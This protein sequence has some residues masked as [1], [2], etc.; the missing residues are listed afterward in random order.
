MCHFISCSALSWAT[1]QSP[2]QTLTFQQL[3]DTP[4][5]TALQRSGWGPSACCPEALPCSAAFDDGS[6]WPLQMVLPRQRTTQCYSNLNKNIFFLLSK[7]ARTMERSD[8]E[9][10]RRNIIQGPCGLPQ[11]TF[12]PTLYLGLYAGTLSFRNTMEMP[13]RNRQV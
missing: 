7:T 11:R 8:K 2:V 10:S 4:T 1:F 13:Y 6:E 5:P 9:H 3:H 12:L